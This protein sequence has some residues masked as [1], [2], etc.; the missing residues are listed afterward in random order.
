MIYLNYF[1]F[2][3]IILRPNIFPEVTVCA[4]LATP[5]YKSILPEITVCAKLATP[6]TAVENVLPL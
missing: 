4:K 1:D 2:L 3:I 5:I 6:I